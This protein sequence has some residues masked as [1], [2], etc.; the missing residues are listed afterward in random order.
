MTDAIMST[1]LNT[2]LLKEI[3]LEKSLETS[4][5]V[6]MYQYHTLYSCIIILLNLCLLCVKK[7]LSFHTFT[8]KNYI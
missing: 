1:V 2:L 8:L 6:V 3:I 4:R 5:I 7:Y